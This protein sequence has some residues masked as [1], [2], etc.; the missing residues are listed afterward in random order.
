MYIL[1][2]TIKIKSLQ[3]RNNNNVFFLLFL[4]KLYSKY[5][6]IGILPYEKYLTLNQ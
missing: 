4:F 6:I 1:V 5:L 3:E 2:F